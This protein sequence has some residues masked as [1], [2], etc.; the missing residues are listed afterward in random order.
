MEERTKNSYQILELI[1][2]G[3]KEKVGLI[4]AQQPSEEII[5]SLLLATKEVAIEKI[6]ASL[7]IYAA[8]IVSREKK[9]LSVL[10]TKSDILNR[11]NNQVDYALKSVKDVETAK[12]FRIVCE[13]LRENLREQF[14]ALNSKKTS[15]KLFRK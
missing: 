11:F 4:L 7:K 6:N 3:E 2:K 9:E 13:E 10:A 12:T 15:K 14:E 8:A 5:N 1:D